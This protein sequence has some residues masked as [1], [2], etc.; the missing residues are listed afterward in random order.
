MSGSSNDLG[1]LGGDRTLPI[2]RMTT[3]QREAPRGTA[4]LWADGPTSYFN[5][6]RTLRTVDPTEL[7][8]ELDK[9]AWC[10]RQDLDKP[11]L[12]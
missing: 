6:S 10:Y 2:R 7:E 12:V 3:A 9:K 1:Y 5:N 8:V 4:G 11:T